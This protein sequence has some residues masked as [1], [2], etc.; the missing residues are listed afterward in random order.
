[1][2]K[3]Q[4]TPYLPFF[5]FWM[6]SI[7]ASTILAFWKDLKPSMADTRDF[8]RRWSCSTMLFRYLQLRILTGFAPRKLNSFRMPM[9][10]SAQ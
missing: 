5:N 3:L 2:P 6:S 4:G 9:R 8:T 10:R 1:M 7:P